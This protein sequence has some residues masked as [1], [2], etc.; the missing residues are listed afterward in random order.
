MHVILERLRFLE[1]ALLEPTTPWR[2]ALLVG[3]LGFLGGLVAWQRNSALSNPR[4]PY[5]DGYLKLADNVVAGH[6]F[7]FEPNGPL[8]THR[9]PLYVMLLIP[10]ALLPSGLEVPG[11]IALHAG[12][13]AATVALTFRVAR[14]LGGQQAGSVTPWLLLAQ[15]IM[16]KSLPYMAPWFLE[17]GLYLLC[18]ERIFHLAMTT[19]EVWKSQPRAARLWCAIELGILAAAMCLTH[20]S[21]PL[22]LAAVWSAAAVWMARNGRLVLWRPLAIAALL[23]MAAVAPWAWRTSKAMG[24]PTLA[25]TN[26]GF[27][28]FLGNAMWA[29]DERSPADR[30]TWQHMALRDA[31][32]SA[33]PAAVVHHWGLIDPEI[34][35]QVNQRMRHHMRTHPGLVACKVT[36]QAIEF[37]LPGLWPMYQ[38]VCVSSERQISRLSAR[39]IAFRVAVSVYNLGLI[40]L[41]LLSLTRLARGTREA[42][43]G[44][45][46]LLGITAFA[47]P[48]FPFLVKAGIS[49]YTIPTLPLWVALAAP[50]VARWLNGSQVCGDP[51]RLAEQRPE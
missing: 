12:L 16:V 37:Y 29:L 2:A 48:Y 1:R 8:V 28:Y 36:L 31:G 3:C 41:G 49:N 47:V 26:A 23:A 44:W 11:M 45:W 7:R 46:L 22:T 5:M 9:P 30:E 19:S 24:R 42:A 35:R 6:G 39:E 34:D 50:S 21:R 51:D 17:A 32:I 20:A 14:T 43:A 4:S 10:I 38:R 13:L 40:A 18:L 27:S 15:P 25:G 33:K